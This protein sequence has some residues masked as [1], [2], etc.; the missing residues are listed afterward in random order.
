MAT[1]AGPIRP[2]LD[3]AVITLQMT[4]PLD[5][6][7]P[8]RSTSRAV[9]RVLYHRVPVCLMRHLPERRG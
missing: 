8:L 7:P 4:P 5:E 3:G 1:D 9:F 6:R 2:T